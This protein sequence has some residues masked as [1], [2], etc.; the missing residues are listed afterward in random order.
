MTDEQQTALHAARLYLINRALIYAAIVT[1][2]E[3]YAA[4]STA[5]HQLAESAK[6]FAR[7]VDAIDPKL[8]EPPQ[9]SMIQEMVRDGLAVPRNPEHVPPSERG[10]T[11]PKP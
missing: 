8:W 5:E 6:N 10:I 1:K 9:T 3:S 4:A 7:T 2:G 11:I